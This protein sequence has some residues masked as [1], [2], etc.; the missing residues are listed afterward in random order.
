M[1]NRPYT[2]LKFVRGSF[3]VNNLGK[4]TR[5]HRRLRGSSSLGG[6]DEAAVRHARPVRALGAGRDAYRCSAAASRA[7]QVAAGRWNACDRHC[8]G[9]PAAAASYAGAAWRQRDERPAR[10]AA[11]DRRRGHLLLLLH[12]C[13][14]PGLPPR[15]LFC[16][17]AHVALTRQPRALG[18]RTCT[19]RRTAAST[20]PL[21]SSRW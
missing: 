3:V 9:P 8:G 12:L 6:D 18:R 11:C 20:L 14:A 1:R 7:A 2:V 16:S 17:H 15:G 13:R 4:K 21:R 19:R 10:A 5:H